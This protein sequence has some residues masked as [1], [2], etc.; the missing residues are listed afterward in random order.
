VKRYFEIATGVVKLQHRS[1]ARFRKTRTRGM[2][3]A[4]GDWVEA[5]TRTAATDS[6][7]RSVARLRSR[8]REA[9]NP[10]SWGRSIT[11]STITCVVYTTDSTTSTG[12]LLNAPRSFPL[13]T[14][15]TIAL[16]AMQITRNSTSVQEKEY[17]FDLQVE[18]GDLSPGE[19]NTSSSR[20]YSKG[21]GIPI[22]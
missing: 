22:D 8:E 4:E 5:W 18:W 21:I 11:S 14:T 20:C 15:A 17:R 16:T 7:A 13:S 2:W 3:V 19:D 12:L 6:R 10:R 9:R 1:L